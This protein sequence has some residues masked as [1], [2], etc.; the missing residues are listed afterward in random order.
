MSNNGS[1]TER[2]GETTPMSAIS[3]AAGESEVHVGL[4]HEASSSNSPSAHDTGSGEMES[5]SAPAVG[6]TSTS[7]SQLGLYDIRSDDTVDTAEAPPP[8]DSDELSR[9]DVKNVDIPEQG[10]ENERQ[11]EQNDGWVHFDEEERNKFKEELQPFT[12]IISEAEA[13]K[14]KE[15]LQSFGEQVVQLIDELKACDGVERHSKDLSVF[16][17]SQIH[18][19]CSGHISFSIVQ[20]AYIRARPV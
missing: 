19:R 12:M 9:A 20:T 6:Q 17:H 18:T 13:I 10:V 15:R 14:C 11:G 2:E 16:E 3:A 4:G 1:L 8:V 7:E 5:S